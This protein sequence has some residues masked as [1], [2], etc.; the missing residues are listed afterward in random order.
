MNNEFVVSQAAGVD[1]V[2]R[3]REGDGVNC[4]W[5]WSNNSETPILIIHVNK[6]LATLHYFPSDDHPGFYS[7]GAMPGL[8]PDKDTVFF[9]NNSTEEELFPNY[10]VVMFSAALVAAKE[11]LASPE[12]PPSIQWFEL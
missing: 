1:A 5:L 10:K 11:F 12:L 3:K 8:D 6:D 4:F 7:E 9:M 2:L